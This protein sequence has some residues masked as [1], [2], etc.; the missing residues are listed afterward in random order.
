M[1][2]AKFTEIH[3]NIRKIG[4]T[5]PRITE[6]QRNRVQVYV[7]FLAIE[8]AR[9]RTTNTAVAGFKIGREVS[10]AGPRVDQRPDANVTWRPP[11]TPVVEHW[12]LST[13]WPLTHWPHWQLITNEPLTRCPEHLSSNTDHCLLTDHWPTDHADHWPPMTHWPHWQLTTNEPLT[14][15][16]EHLSSNTDHCPLSDHFPSGHTDNWPP[17]THWPGARSTCRRTAPSRRL[18]NQCWTCLGYSVQCACVHTAL[19]SSGSLVRYLDTMPR[20]TLADSTP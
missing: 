15:C 4:M 6:I 3:R 8:M 7:I 2:T 19:T 5:G 11:G 18:N 12:Q 10:L 1:T 9:K 16:P 14:R 17:M 20:S 13:Q